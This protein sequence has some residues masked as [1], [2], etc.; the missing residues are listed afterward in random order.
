MKRSQNLT[1]KRGTIASPKKMIVAPLAL[2][3]SMLST[4]CSPSTTEASLYKDAESCVAAGNDFNQCQNQFEQAEIVHQQTAPKFSKLEEC[5]AEYG[6][7][8]CGEQQS[9][10]GGGSTFMPMMMGYMMG[11][12]LSSNSSA[13]Q[14]QPLYNDRKSSGFV[15]GTGANVGKSYGNAVVPTAIA[16]K[17]PTVASAMSPSKAAAAARGGFGGKSSGSFGG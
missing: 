6:K 14:A 13:V 10:G 8:Y 2:A 5:E 7:G 3:I 9:S 16:G 11:S 1:I 12:M 17:A 4:G 15:T